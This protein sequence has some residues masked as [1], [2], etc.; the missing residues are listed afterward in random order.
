MRKCPIWMPEGN[1]WT[2]AGGTWHIH[3]YI[4]TVYTYVYIYTCTCIYIHAHA[5]ALVCMCMCVCV[6]ETEP[7]WKSWIAD[8][9]SGERIKEYKLLFCQDCGSRGRIEAL[10]IKSNWHKIEAKSFW[11]NNENKY[12]DLRSIWLSCHADVK[13]TLSMWMDTDCT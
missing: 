5:R 7:H 11:K 1:I 6:Y 13:V 4:H 10:I 9:S 2:V 8:S 12:K 3:T